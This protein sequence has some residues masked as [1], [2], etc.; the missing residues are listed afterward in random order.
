[1]KNYPIEEI[2]N[3]VINSKVLYL[4]GY[5]EALAIFNSYACVGMQYKLFS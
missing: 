5:L 1:M 3:E 2:E 4:N